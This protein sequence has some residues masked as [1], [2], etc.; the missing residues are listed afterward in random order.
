MRLLSVKRASD[1][2]HKYVA[3]FETDAGRHRRTYFGAA[4]MDD[5]TLTHDVGQRA[6]YRER[7]R[8]DLETGDPTRAGFLSYYI[9]WGDSTSV[10]ENIA[11]FKNRFNL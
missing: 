10:R 7:H 11:H 5:Y 1:G 3:E 6:R 4:G 2:K 8:K 9:L